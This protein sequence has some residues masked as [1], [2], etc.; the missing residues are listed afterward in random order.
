MRDVEGSTLKIVEYHTFA[1]GPKNRRP[2][3]KVVRMRENT[4]LSF[5]P[6]DSPRSSS[7]AHQSDKPKM[8]PAVIDL[9]RMGLRVNC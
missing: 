7:W 4:S 6:S 9:V 1:A 8:M 2:T 3:R 5:S